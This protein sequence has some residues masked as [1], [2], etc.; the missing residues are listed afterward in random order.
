MPKQKSDRAA[1]EAKAIAT[2]L[3]AIKAVQVSMG[4]VH[5]PMINLLALDTSTRDFLTKNG[6]LVNLIKSQSSFTHC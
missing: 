3:K 4:V 6:I 5:E 1:A 2:G